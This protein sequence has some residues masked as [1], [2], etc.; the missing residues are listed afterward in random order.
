MTPCLRGAARADRLLSV[1]IQGVTKV[2]ELD[3]QFP[4]M[5]A[6]EFEKRRSDLRVRNRSGQ[7]TLVCGPGGEG[8]RSPKAHS[9]VPRASRRTP[10][11]RGEGLASRDDRG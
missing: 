10:S 8:R 4:S 6:S 2:H 7:E 9:T 11:A 1:I 3:A 5:R